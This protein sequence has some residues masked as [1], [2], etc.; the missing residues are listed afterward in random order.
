[1]PAYKLGNLAP[2]IAA[3]A[4]MAP[5]ATVLGNVVLAEQASVWFGT[6]IRGDNELIRIGEGSNVLVPDTG[7]EGV[8][9]RV[10][11]HDLTFEDQ[12]DG[13]VHVSAGAGLLNR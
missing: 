8:V 11:L 12:S 3:S 5:N 10:A 4:Y 7:V 1:M 9:L 6:T 13:T 2:R